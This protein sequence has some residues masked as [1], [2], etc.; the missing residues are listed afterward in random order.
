MVQSL[1]LERCKLKFHRETR[2]F[3]VYSL[4]LAKGGSK[5]HPVNASSTLSDKDA[6]IRVGNG[7][8]IVKDYPM[9]SFAKNLGLNIG[10]VVV[11]KTGLLG[12]VHTTTQDGV[13][14]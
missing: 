13:R 11:D 12:P 14:V 9:G 6:S 3:S 4:Q 8:F 10:H 1:L 5:L 7:E 2:I